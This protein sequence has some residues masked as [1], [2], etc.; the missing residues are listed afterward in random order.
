MG[1]V[2]DRTQIQF[3]GT[4][5]SGLQGCIDANIHYSDDDIQNAVKSSY[6]NSGMAG[7]ESN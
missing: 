6:I 3:G 1:L 5:L 2:F 4:S 7:L